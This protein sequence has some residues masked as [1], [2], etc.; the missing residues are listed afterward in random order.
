MSAQVIRSMPPLDTRAVHG[1]E[2]RLAAALKR[3]ECVLQIQ[4]HL[5]QVSRV[6]ASQSFWMLS[7]RRHH[8][9]QVNA[10]W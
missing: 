4:N 10:R 3:S 7:L 5:A 1:G 9:L 8:H 2:H 6:R